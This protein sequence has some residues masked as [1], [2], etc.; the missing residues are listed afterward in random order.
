MVPEFQAAAA[1]AA[2]SASQATLLISIYQNKVSLFS[3]PFLLPNYAFLQGS[4]TY[5]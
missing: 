4:S 1:A 2:A 5:K 3:K